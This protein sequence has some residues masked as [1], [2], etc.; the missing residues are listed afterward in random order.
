MATETAGELEVTVVLRVPAPVGAHL[1]EEIALVER[2]YSVDGACRQFLAGFGVEVPQLQVDG[3]A[4]AGVRGV[5]PRQRLHRGTF[6]PRV[7]RVEPSRGQRHVH[8]LERRLVVVRRAVVAIDAIHGTFESL[9]SLVRQHGIAERRPT[10]GV[11]DRRSVLPPGHLID[12]L[13]RRVGRHVRHV[14]RR[15]DVPVNA[16]R[17]SARRL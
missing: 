9:R 11:G 15:V 3:I 7:L 14:V 16:R 13:S 2:S 17:V 6:D 12:R 1:W 10:A 5:A 4:R 8:R